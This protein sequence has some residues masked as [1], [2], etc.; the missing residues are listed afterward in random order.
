MFFDPC[1][2]VLQILQMLANVLRMKRLHN[3]WVTNLHYTHCTLRVFLLYLPVSIKFVLIVHIHPAFYG[4][5]H[6]MLEN[7]YKHLKTTTNALPTIR[8][9]C[10]WLQ[11]C[12][13]YAHFR[14]IFLIFVTPQN[15][16]GIHMKVYEC[17]A[18]TLQTVRIGG[19]AFVS[20]LVR[21]SLQCNSNYQYNQ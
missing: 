1:K 20:Q 13:K 12:C 10:N 16:A 9:A 6:T 2:S 17:L 7:L 11:I 19:I 8:I 21:Y 3:A 14:S 5:V 18:I 4:N 15:R